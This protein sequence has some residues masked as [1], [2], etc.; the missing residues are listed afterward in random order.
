M[1]DLCPLRPDPWLGMQL[2]TLAYGLRVD[3]LAPEA[4]LPVLDLP[5]GTFIHARVPVV[6]T[7][8]LHAL[9]QEGFLLV[10]TVLI[11]ER[12]ESFPPI[13]WHSSIREA[14]PEDAPAVIELAR[15]ACLYDRFH[16]DPHIPPEIA[17]A[18]QAEI[19]GSFFLGAPHEKM[20]VAEQD[21]TLLGFLFI[22]FDI[23]NNTPTLIIDTLAV[24]PHAR[25]Q[26]IAH[27]LIDQSL[28][29]TRYTHA[30]VGTQLANT[31]AL[32]LYQK[33]GF[34]VKEAFYILHRHG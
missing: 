10:E 33:S 14:R 17:D 29:R 1:T 25:R 9:I 34:I 3:L 8:R 13:F 28:E 4:L 16:Q 24:A 19:V 20:F 6:Q 26:G 27:A 12:D 15:H 5:P 30:R 22:R 31:P 18:I 7:A 32:Q 2:R 21:N 23:M 11:L